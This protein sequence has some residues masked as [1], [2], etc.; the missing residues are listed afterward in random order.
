MLQSITKYQQDIPTYK[1][2]RQPG[3]TL[4][5]REDPN[6]CS[7]TLVKIPNG[8]RDF[9]CDHLGND[10]WKPSVTVSVCLFFEVLFLDFPGRGGQ[11]TT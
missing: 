5:A 3:K 1:A 6:Q 8:I 10:T 9:R 2:T 4:V 11:R 7:E